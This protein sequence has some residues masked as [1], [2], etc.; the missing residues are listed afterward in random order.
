M[1][2]DVGLILGDRGVGG[3][4]GGLVGGGV[5]FELALFYDAD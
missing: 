2:G 1:M 4:G 3:M 5:G